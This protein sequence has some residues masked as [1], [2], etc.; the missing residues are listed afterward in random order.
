LAR[1]ARIKL[2][3]GDGAAATRFLRE[4]E[5]SLVSENYA[6]VCALIDEVRVRL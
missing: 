3:Q 6:L 4:A 2:A 5:R 1:L